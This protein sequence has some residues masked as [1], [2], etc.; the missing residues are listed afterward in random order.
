MT[1][2]WTCRRQRKGVK[3]GTRNPRVKR[4]CVKCGGSRPAQRKPAHARALE[5][6]RDEWQR[7][8][9][10]R[11]NI[12]GAGRKTR[13]LDRDHWHNGPRAGEPRGLLCSR[14]NRALP[15]WMTV[16]WLRAAAD[17][18]ERDQTDQMEAA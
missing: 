7:R 2:Y 5:V 9:G 12:C 1:R 18:L 15:N 17:Y 6:P 4:K 16:V 3:C 11:C 13:R 14:C 8:Y 10:E